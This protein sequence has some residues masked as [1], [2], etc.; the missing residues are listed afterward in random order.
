[1][2]SWCTTLVDS[3]VI[4]DGSS[5]DWTILFA[6]ANT[7]LFAMLTVGIRWVLL[8]HPTAPV[9]AAT[10]IGVLLQ[11]GGSAIWMG[12]QKDSPVISEDLG[13]ALIAVDALC[14]ALFWFCIQQASKHI[15]ATELNLVMML[16][17]LIA[18]IWTYTLHAEVPTV[19]T[20]AG[21]MIVLAVLAYHEVSSLS[22]ADAPI[23]KRKHEDEMPA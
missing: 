4:G 15:T 22:A 7:V 1:M 14:M 6:I 5:L 16:E 12:V 10:G 18:P 21:G 20:I 9:S 23:P 2:H 8:T 19:Y 13:W 3:G 17:V 11:A